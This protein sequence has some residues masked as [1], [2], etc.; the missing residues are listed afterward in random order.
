MT[1]FLYRA[2]FL[3]LLLGSLISTTTASEETEAELSVNVYEGPTSNGGECPSLDETITEGKY[4]MIHFTVSVADSSKTGT[5]G[6]EFQSTKTEGQPIGVTIGLGEV[7]PGWDQGLLGLCQGDKVVL[8]VPPS[9]AYGND[10]TGTGEDDIPGGAT[11]KFDIEIVTVMEGPSEDEDEEQAK[12]MFDGA[13][14]DKDGKLSRAEFDE[15]FASQIGEVSDPEEMLVISQQLDQFWDTQNLDGD[16]FLTLDEFM[17]P[18]GFDGEGDEEGYGDE[19]T[20]EE[21]FAELDT[22][23]DGKLSQSEVESFFT[24]LGQPVPDDFWEHLDT[25]QDGFISFDEFFLANEG[26]EQELEDEL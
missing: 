21:E 24:V 3:S 15:M 23:S 2:L 8:V 17:A 19:N 20:P 22:D 12:A 18:T 26:D 11:I 16:D 14:T 9:M 10:G 5:P 25:N 13:D 6:H 1:S 4:A 7:I